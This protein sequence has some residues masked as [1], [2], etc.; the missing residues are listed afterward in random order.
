MFLGVQ[1][2][3]ERAQRLVQ[4]VVLSVIVLDFIWNLAAAF[5]VLFVIDIVGIDKLGILLAVSFILQSALDYPSGVIGDW[6]G[7]RWV[8]LIGFL[9]D[10]LAFGAL[11]FADSFSSLFV[12][13]ILRAIAFSQQSG[14]I[15][16]WL[17]NNYKI[18]ADEVDPQRDVYKLF[19]GRWKTIGM[20]IPAI[21]VIIGGIIATVYRRQVVFAIQAIGLTVIAILFLF[22]V[23][24]FPEIERPK[25]SFQNYL[26]LLGEGLRF[27]INS[28]MMVF[29]I[30]GICIS[31]AMS[32][33]WFEMIL[34]PLYFG[35]TGSDTGTSILRFI[36]LIVGMVLAF[37]ASKVAVKLDV[38]WIPWL[39][40]IDS[41]IFFWGIALL[42]YWF[43]IDRNTFTPVAIVITVVIYAS[44][45]FFF[46]IADILHQRIFLDFIPDRNRNSIYSLIPT[47]I[48]LVTAPGVVIG[49]IL[50]KN[51][52]VPVTSFLLGSIGIIAVIFYY[53]SLRYMPQDA[54]KHKKV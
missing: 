44:V 39:R 3:P 53:I 4:K 2:L 1:D 6:V 28:P 34:F 52:D 45:W 31:A 27:V 43:P 40:L 42:T 48:L 17:D 8:L 18:A 7:Q 15:S 9:I 46:H 41:T 25:R 19:M 32:I 22:I 12:I 21:S 13:Y 10:G 51:L 20:L 33:I 49:G 38:K 23:K 11:F 5:Y 26:K 36:V 50:L 35:Y 29:F 37:Y 54:L 30:A 14:A 24:D 16:T 47:L